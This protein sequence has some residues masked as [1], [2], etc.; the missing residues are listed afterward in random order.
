MKYR[1]EYKEQTEIEKMIGIEDA[2]AYTVRELKTFIENKEY[3][4]KCI[5]KIYN[6]GV[7]VDVTRKYIA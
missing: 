6:D 4:I 5:T 7:V 2:Y 3:K 1:I